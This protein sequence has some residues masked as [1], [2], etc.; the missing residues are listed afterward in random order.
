MVAMQLTQSV[1]SSFLN[2]LFMSKQL[3]A[4]HSIS[5]QS[6]QIIHQNVGIFAGFQTMSL[7]LL[8]GLPFFRNL[9]RSDTRSDKSPFKVYGEVL[10]F[11]AEILKRE[12]FSNRQ[13]SLTKQSWDMRLVPIYL[14][15]LLTLTVEAV[16]TIILP[17]S[18]ELRLFE[19]WKSVLL[20]VFKLWKWSRFFS[21]HISATEVERAMKIAVKIHQSPLIHPVQELC[22]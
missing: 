3:L 19:G 18:N 12:A 11:R 1:H 15:T 16:F 5:T 6:P 4:T 9:P 17:L 10:K 14:Q 7:S 20:S 8:W 13:I 22:C 2:F 21:R